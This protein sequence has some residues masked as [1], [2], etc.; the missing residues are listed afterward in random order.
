M[1]VQANCCHTLA[2]IDLFDYKRFCLQD[3]S[4][5]TVRGVA[6]ISIHKIILVVFS[7]QIKV[8]GCQYIKINNGTKTVC[9]YKC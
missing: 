7:L 4:G 3:N 6:D 9:R 5:G 2:L 1:L 8:V